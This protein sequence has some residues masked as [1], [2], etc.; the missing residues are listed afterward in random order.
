MCVCV[1]VFSFATS[2]SGIAVPLEVG[3]VERGPSAPADNARPTR[4]LGPDTGGSQY[5]RK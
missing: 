1:Y 2:G 4:R 5:L 3:L